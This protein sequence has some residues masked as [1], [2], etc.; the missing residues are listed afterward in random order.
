MHILK[1]TPTTEILDMVQ[2]GESS[3]VHGFVI[4]A[5]KSRLEAGYYII[6]FNCIL[7]RYGSLSL[8]LLLQRITFLEIGMIQLYTYIISVMSG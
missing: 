5:G 4:N 6:T 1:R 7:V 2:Y 8:L 3:Y